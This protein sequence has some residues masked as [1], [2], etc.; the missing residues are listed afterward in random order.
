M[1]NPCSLNNKIKYLDFYKCPYCGNLINVTIWENFKYDFSCPK[2][3]DKTIRC[4]CK[5]SDY[6]KVRI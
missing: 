3:F 5:V 2:S 1:S 4:L 6:I